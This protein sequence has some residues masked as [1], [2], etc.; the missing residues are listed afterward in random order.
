MN[1]PFAK[2]AKGGETVQLVDRSN[3]FEF[4]CVTARVQNEYNL[5][6]TGTAKNIP[7]KTERPWRFEFGGSSWGTALSATPRKGG[8]LVDVTAE[9]VITDNGASGFVGGLFSIQS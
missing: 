5:R 3:Q 1:L 8:E 7:P 2:L 4:T 6:I 9:V